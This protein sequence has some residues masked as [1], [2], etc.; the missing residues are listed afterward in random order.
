MLSTIHTVEVVQTG[1]K[2]RS[3]WSR[4]KR[5][6]GWNYSCIQKTYKWTTKLFFHFLEEAIF[7]SFLLYSN[8]ND[9][10]KFMEYKV[11]VVR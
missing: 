9:E 3:E 2:D 5:R 7:N 1:K 4:Q 6:S 8:S 10:K 11:E